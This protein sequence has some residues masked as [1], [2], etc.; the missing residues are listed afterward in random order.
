[1]VRS[2]TD[3]AGAPARWW[4]AADGSS[5]GEPPGRPVE[6]CLGLPD[7]RVLVAVGATAW[8]ACCAAGVALGATAW[9]RRARYPG[10]ASDR[11]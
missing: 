5:L 10:P 7:G 11:R 2:G 4:A 9:V 6:W 8:A 1:M 3:R